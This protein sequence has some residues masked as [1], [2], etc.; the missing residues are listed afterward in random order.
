MQIGKCC[1]HENILIS[2]HKKSALI[3]FDEDLK[4]TKNLLNVPN[5]EIVRRSC[6]NYM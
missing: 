6:S 3:G 1:F 2:Y 4:F 5:K